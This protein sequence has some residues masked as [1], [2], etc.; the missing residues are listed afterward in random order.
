M[1]R[2]NFLAV[3]ATGA[4]VL[5]IPALSSCFPEIEYDAS[6][7]EPHAL[8]HIWDTESIQIIGER[9]RQQF[10]KENTERSLVRSLLQDVD[11]DKA[12]PVENMQQKVTEDYESK[13]IV[14]IDGWLLSLTEARQCALF[15][16]LQT[17]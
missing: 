16:L 7:A 3:A 11:T 5:T 10:P 4:F 2:R 13:E 17:K 12:S 6:I 8:S 15:S 14:M 9:Y 1:K